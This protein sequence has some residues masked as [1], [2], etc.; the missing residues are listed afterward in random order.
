[1]FTD[2]QAAILSTRRPKSQSGQYILRRIWDLYSQLSSEGV[3]VEIRWIPSHEGVPGNK[4]VDD[5]AKRAAGWRPVP[6]NYKGVVSPAC[7]APRLEWAQ[8]LKSACKRQYKKITEAWWASNWKKGSTGREYFK[9]AGSPSKKLMEAR[10]K[11]PKALGSIITQMRTG[12]I[13]LRQYL[14]KIKKADTEQC[15]C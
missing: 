3:Q 4:A 12:K 13:G 6:G 7:R 8:R 1:M 14:A 10:D 9:I 5:L 15:Q 2:N 11:G